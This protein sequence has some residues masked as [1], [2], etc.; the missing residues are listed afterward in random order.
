[1]KGILFILLFCCFGRF[2]FAQEA[3]YDVMA[4]EDETKHVNDR[5]AVSLLMINDLEEE[6]VVYWMNARK[7]KTEYARLYEGEEFAV[8]SATNH[9]WVFEGDSTCLGILQPKTSGDIHFSNLSSEPDN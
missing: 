4:C 3:T 7:Q 6:I 1:M 5:S 8:N 9:Y 2:L